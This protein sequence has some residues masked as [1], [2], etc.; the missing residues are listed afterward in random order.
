MKDTPQRAKTATEAWKGGTG[1][2]CHPLWESKKQ[3][4]N[5]D[6]LEKHQ[7]KKKKVIHAEGGAQKSYS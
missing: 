5:S 2:W 6:I 4:E 7:E 3:R 1:K